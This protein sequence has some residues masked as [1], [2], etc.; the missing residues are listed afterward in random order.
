MLS[1]RI[2]TIQESSS[3]LSKFINFLSI[4]PSSFSSSNIIFSSSKSLIFIYPLI[5]QVKD[6]I[7]VCITRDLNFRNVIFILLQ[8]IK[9][10]NSEISTLS[11]YEKEIGL[12][13]AQEFIRE[14]LGNLGFSHQVVIILHTLL[15]I[16][17]MKS[18]FQVLHQSS[19]SSHTSSEI[20][21]DDKPDNTLDQVVDGAL[22]MRNEVKE[23]AKLLNDKDL[24]RRMFKATDTFRDELRD[25]GY[26]L[27]DKKS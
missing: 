13:H 4:S 11:N 9:K 16:L 27:R 23:V 12:Y 26:D 10:V 17:Y 20:N 5:S 15:F 3:I 22:R 2:E 7:I 6:E 19:I 1:C 14:I 8:F 24:K 21:E 25:I 18:H